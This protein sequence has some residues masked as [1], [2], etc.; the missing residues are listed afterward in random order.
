VLL[1]LAAATT[2]SMP[3][4]PELED[5]LRQ[6]GQLEELAERMADFRARGAWKADHIP[7]AVQKTDGQPPLRD[8]GEVDTINVIVLLVDFVD[9]QASDGGV[10][11]TAAEFNYQ[12]FS[13]SHLDGHYSMTE[14]YLDNSY[15]TFYIRGNVAGWYRL[16]HSYDWYVQGNNGWGDYP[17][18]AQGMAE[19]AVLA[20]DPD[21]DYSI[22]DNDGD[23]WIDGI[24]IVHAGTGAEQSGSDYEIW[25]H[26][27]SLPGTLNLDGVNISEYTTEPEETNGV[28]MMTI[29]VFAHEFG[30]F[31]GLP[32]LYDTDY[33]S[34]GIGN[35][36]LMAG[37][38]WNMG[39]ARPAFMDAWCKSQLGFLT[40]VN[41]TD[42]LIDVEIPSV[43]FNP[44]AY[45]VWA[46]GTVG[47]QYFLVENRQK[48]G[49][50]PGIPGSGLVIYHIDESQWGN[51]D[52]THPLVGVEQADGLFHLESGTNSGDGHD[53]WYDPWRTAFDDLS[54]PN[55]HGYGDVPTR[56]GVY[57]I[58][59][60][61]SIMYASFDIEYS[62]PRYEL[63]SSVFDDADF[64]NGNGIAE[65]GESITFEFAINNLWLES[66]NTQATLYCD[67]NDITFTT[68]S[69]SL[70]TVA[71]EG[72]VANNS[73]SPLVFAIP[74]GFSSCIDSFFLVISSDSPVGDETFGF[75]MYLGLPQVL[76]V[77]DDD[78]DAWQEI[79]GEQLTIQRVPFDVHDK[80][81]LGS[82]S[83]ADLNA[84]EMVIWL[85]GDSRPDVLSA[86]DVLSMESFLDGGGNLFL[87]GQSIVRELDA[88]NQTFLHNYL[89]TE[90]IFDDQVPF[91]HGNANSPIGA[92]IS[93]R[94]RNGTNQTDP[95]VID[96][97]NGSIP[98]F[99][100]DD[101][102]VT[103]LSYGGDYRLVLFSFGF[104]GL[105]SSHVSSGYAVQETLFKRV[106]AFLQ[107]QT[108]SLNPIVAM[109]SIEGEL[110]TN[111][112]GHTPQFNWSVS[113]TTGNS[114]E[115]YQVRLGSGELCSNR[116]DLWDP[117][118]LMG[119]DS[120][121]TY[122]GDPLEDGHD[123]YFGVRAYNGLSWSGWST[124]SFRLN[125][126]GDG[127]LQINPIDGALIAALPP[128]LTVASP[129]DPEDDP[130]TLDFEVF[131]DADLT[132]L[133]SSVIGLPVTPLIT[134]WTVSD[135]LD[136]DEE[137]FWRVRAH[138]GFE[139]SPY[140]TVRSMFI[141][142]TNQ[143]PQPFDLILP[144]DGD[145]ISETYPLLV[146]NST[147]D[148][149][150]GDEVH[151]R[152]EF[153]TD[154]T[155]ATALVVDN[156][157]DTALYSPVP[158]QPETHYYWRVKAVDVAGDSTYAN[159][160]FMFGTFAAGCCHLR[161]DIDDN[162][163]GPDIVDLIYLVT[164]MFQNGN[165][166]PCP[167]TADINDDGDPEPNISDLI[168][169]VVYM[170]QEGPPLPLC[171]A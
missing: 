38:S 129:T 170:F 30:H 120:S 147:T 41:V 26:M 134:A 68:Q 6:S 83:A 153:G 96:T 44:V 59:E 115:Q 137:F 10:D 2:W 72:G 156:I 162:G 154:P 50:D 22:Y 60:S 77:D 37:G 70:G 160:E 27:W 63:A 23:G 3:P 128:E 90:Y 118:A 113:D 132:E 52:E 45:R 36:S 135:A 80:S 161:G 71:G 107:G 1:I 89:R 124:L 33:S 82:P 48:G 164:Y 61:D 146:W 122:D 47:N 17:Q 166:L 140:S 88:Q 87:T 15:G 105:S 12:L 158:T 168:R 139:Y 65:E 101:D 94:L 73:G 81:L 131:A 171:G 148:N 43:K 143:A 150:I 11:A 133:V 169:L 92:G 138:D 28:G 7:M 46:N 157:Y 53:A 108:S 25:S 91:M 110:S 16:P 64:G 34:S 75:E 24:F 39:G 5:R 127:V 106:L 114:V 109:P 49:L 159:S 85:T 74:S 151:Y 14:F 67:N 167:E 144:P 99:V 111:V 51:E 130:Q 66:S 93:V 119:S 86:T 112:V 136:E 62:H 32:D 20:A 165:A 31:I 117:G 58:S 152:L 142:G 121:V 8:S 95:Q 145:T 125:G 102:E 4:S 29:G 42:N 57:R 40:P 100:S 116:D 69:V 163:T 97:I 126:V 56:A 54:L 141:N 55:T 104:E 78:G 84:Y 9:N 98:A 13:K 123:Y 76:I 103:A 21:V 35:W 79:Y 149:D 19:D 18:N 155:F